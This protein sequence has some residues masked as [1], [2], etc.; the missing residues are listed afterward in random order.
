MFR[1]QTPLHSAA[2]HGNIDSMKI[3]LQNGA[4]INEKDVRIISLGKSVGLEEKE[5]LEREKEREERKR[6]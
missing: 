5:E 6:E 3:L 2:Y 1:Y 4:N